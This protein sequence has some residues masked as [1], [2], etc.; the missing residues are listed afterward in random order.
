[1]GHFFSE[2]L[3]TF[4]KL[5]G[6]AFH[7]SLEVD[8]LIA[9]LEKLGCSNIRGEGQ[10]LC[11]MSDSLNLLGNRADLELSGDLPDVEVIKVGRM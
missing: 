8:E 4:K 11:V 3:T 9:G 10:T 5:L 2:L 6:R 1:M 7:T